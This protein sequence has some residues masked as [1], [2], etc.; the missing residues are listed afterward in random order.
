MAGLRTPLLYIS[1][2]SMRKID[3]KT[4]GTTSGENTPAVLDTA[5]L[6]AA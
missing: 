2:E 3:K 4:I 6:T 1:E 5:E